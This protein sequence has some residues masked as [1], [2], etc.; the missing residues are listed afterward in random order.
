MPDVALRLWTSASA[1][2]FF[3]LLDSSC[4]CRCRCCCRPSAFSAC[5][6]LLAA[7]FCMVL[8]VFSCCLLLLGS[9]CCR[10]CGWKKGCVVLLDLDLLRQ[11]LDRIP[12]A[13]ADSRF[14]NYSIAGCK[15]CSWIWKCVANS[16]LFLCAKRA[17]VFCQ[18]GEEPSIEAFTMGKPCSFLLSFLRPSES[19][20]T[21][22]RPKRTKE[23]SQ[24]LIIWLVPEKTTMF[25]LH[26]NPAGCKC[27]QI[28]LDVTLPIGFVRHSI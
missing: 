16:S 10:V 18:L 21:D 4:C 23:N 3:L 1:V 28:W 12:L 17:V 7:G 19:I 26:K 14:W 2:L 27:N 22:Y 11:N 20:Q 25:H 6:F 8:L 24:K 5:C 15:K 13:Y 9:A